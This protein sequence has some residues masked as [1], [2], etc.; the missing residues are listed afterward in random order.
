MVRLFAVAALSAYVVGT[1]SIFANAAPATRRQLGNLE[2]NIARG[3]IVFHVAQLAATV[4]S[5]ANATDLMAANSTT[6]ADIQAMQTGA[7]GAGAAVKQ[8]LLGLINGDPATPELRDSVGKNLTVVNFALLDLSSKD[9][10]T[11]VLLAQANTELTNAALAGNGV[12][13]NCK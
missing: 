2:C 1:I 12:L 10:T 11:S 13:N 6:D 4:N 3:E 7:Q 5:L 8:I 9:N